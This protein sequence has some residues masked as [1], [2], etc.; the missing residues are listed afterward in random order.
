MKTLKNTKKVLLRA[1]KDLKKEK[2]NR[3]KIDQ[4]VLKEQIIQ[5]QEIQKITADIREKF[6]LGILESHLSLYVS[7][8]ERDTEKV[9]VWLDEIKG[10]K[11]RLSACIPEAEDE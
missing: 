3:G 2:N 8:L 11:S 7:L 10:E 4:S 9:K 1:I 6:H 5:V